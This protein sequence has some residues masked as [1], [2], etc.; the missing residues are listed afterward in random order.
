M[1]LKQPL[2]SKSNSRPSSGGTVSMDGRRGEGGPLASQNQTLPAGGARQSWPIAHIGEGNLRFKIPAGL[3]LDPPIGKARGITPE[4]DSEA[5]IAKAVSSWLQ[6]LTGNSCC[7][8]GPK[9]IG[10]CLSFGSTERGI[11]CVGYNIMLH[12][13]FALEIT[14]RLRLTLKLSMA[15]RQGNPY[16]VYRN[17]TMGSELGSIVDSLFFVHAATDCG[18]T[19]AV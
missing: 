10:L 19:S 5:G 2:T 12:I 11:R 17:V 6:H 14:L 13:N 8:S 16:N 18:T 7:F 9:R 1:L 4:E 3:R 15:G